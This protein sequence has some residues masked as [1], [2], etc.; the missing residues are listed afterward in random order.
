MKS[1]AKKLWKYIEGINGLLLI[2]YSV[3]IFSTS[4]IISNNFSK[5]YFIF[6]ELFIVVLSVIICPIII[7]LSSKICIKQRKIK[8]ENQKAQFF[9]NLSFY[10]IP[11]AILLLY[12]IAYYPG[13]FS[14]DS[15]DQYT[16]A[17][18]NHYN[19]WHP[20]IQTLFA[21]KLPLSLTG[22]WIGSIV[23]FQIICFSVVLGYAFN[24]IYKYTNLK[25]LVLSMSFVLLNPQLGYISLFPWKDV[26]F[27]IG[28]VLSITYSLQI[29]MTKGEW[30]KSPVNTIL[31]IFTVS[32]TT[33][34]RHNAILFTIPLI[35]SILFFLSKKRGFVI[36]LSFVILCLSVK[37][38]LYTAL[39]VEKPGGRQA[40]IL[41]LPMTV[42]GGVVTYN[43]EAL[44]VG[45]RGFAYEV[46]PK[47]VWEEKYT[48]GSFNQVKWDNRTDSGVIEVYGT[49][50][51]VWMMVKSFLS[52]KDEAVKSLIKLT[53]PS[54]SV[55]GD[56]DDFF[57]PRISANNFGITN[58]F[59][60][61]AVAVCEAYRN[62]VKDFVSY[63]FL[64]LG[65]LHLLLIVAILSKCKLNKIRD[66]K[67]ILFVIPIFTYNY[68]TMLLLSGKDLTGIPDSSRFLFYTFLIL[69]IVLIVMF[70]KEKYIDEVKL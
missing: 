38:P 56:Y 54:F 17:I 27:A 31:F 26:S 14:Y 55:T 30:I 20:V 40:E 23:L 15:I 11:F 67:K 58:H 44:D 10:I 5:F 45:V 52:S 61:N 46:A 19:D 28:T 13:G 24:T 68:G 12:Y 51:V 2:L 41:G 35:I 33:L 22:G 48:Y 53:E 66:W 6:S 34:F 47:E 29:F 25:Y 4:V 57:Y 70:N 64:H 36:C 18:E 37:L 43:P 3:F 69:P 63:P 1:A 59:N 49:K 50:Q 8:G 21:F 9:L 32:L 62:F 60:D 7:K 42:I 65:F 39:G 16:Q